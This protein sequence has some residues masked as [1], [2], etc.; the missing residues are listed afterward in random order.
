MRLLALTVLCLLSGLP[1]QATRLLPASAGAWKSNQVEELTPQALEKL[2]ATT[3]PILREYGLTGAERALY[4]SGGRH[5]SATLYRMRDSSAAY[6]AYTL[7]RTPDMV[8]F[9]LGDKSAAGGT[10]AL[11]VVGNLLLDVEHA[12][13]HP[14]GGSESSRVDARPEGSFLIGLKALVA[15]VA[16]AA[17]RTAYPGLDEYLPPQQLLPNSDRY[18]LGPAALER[19]LP[20]TNLQANRFPS[21]G[22]RDGGSSG[23]PTIDWI[24]F[25]DGAEAE[26]ALYQIHNETVSLLLVQYPTR[27]LAA[28]HLEAL[29][30]LF[31]VNPLNDG[32][33]QSSHQEGVNQEAVNHEVAVSGGSRPELFVVRK[34]ALLAI[35]TGTHSPTVAASLIR[36]VQYE[37]QITWSEPSWKATE[38]PF[39]LMLYEVFVGT[40]VI[41]V[42][43]VVASLAFGLIRL[44]IKRVLPNQVFDRPNQIE[45]LQLGIYSKPIEAKDFY[46]DES[47]S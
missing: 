10:R 37:T 1:A 24:G 2:S 5:L 42:Y 22:T 44:T 46:S 13:D 35:V 17:E 21:T 29:G 16:P 32:L 20:R 23:T 28:K 39:A 11:V 36:E 14:R 33:N 7:L 27:Q 6:G 30:K 31:V 9:D 41:L 26:L 18:L 19:F 34:M 25:A 47:K 15:S 38:K 8:A 45:V 3:A 12:S 43:A 4:E 40:G